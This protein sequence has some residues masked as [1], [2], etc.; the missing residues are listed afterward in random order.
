MATRFADLT[1]EGRN[2][3]RHDVHHRLRV[4]QGH[5][6]HYT[7]T[8]VNVSLQGFMARS[9]HDFAVGDRIVVPLPGNGVFDAEVRWALGGRIGCRLDRAIPIAGFYAMLA[10]MTATA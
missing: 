7:V 2:D 5:T 1:H 6:S 3:Q 4:R 8:I 10:T 9:D